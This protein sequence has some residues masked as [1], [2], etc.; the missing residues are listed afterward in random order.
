[1]TLVQG[2]PGTGKTHTAAALL[3]HLLAQGKRVLVTAHTD[4]ALHEV[5]EKRHGDIRPLA[6][7]VV[8][9]SRSDMA[10]LRTAV[11]TISRNSTEHDPTRANSKIKRYLEEVDDLRQQRQTL[12]ETLTESRAS[13]VTPHTFDGYSGTLAE[14]SQAHARD[15]DQ[16]EWITEYLDESAPSSP[17]ALTDVEATEWLHYIQDQNIAEF[18]QIQHLRSLNIDELPS[19]EQ[20]FEIVGSNQQAATRFDHYTQ[21][22]THNAWEP[23][24]ACDRSD[25]DDLRNRLSKISEIHHK[26]SQLHAAWISTAVQDIRAGIVDVWAS[27]KDDVE[28]RV[29]YVEER[30]GVLGADFRAEV[31]GDPDTHLQFAHALREY[32]ANGNEIKT[33][34]D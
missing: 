11:D 25:R 3:S 29:R 32:A 1:Q 5:G 19:P 28:N 7:S 6:V 22:S 4:R 27:R 31:S 12:N 14:I 26:T 13:E 21:A 17:L 15:A 23:I 10:Q 9:S 8:V 30:I 18:S 34:I 33:Q 16:F 24:L 20:F 2:P